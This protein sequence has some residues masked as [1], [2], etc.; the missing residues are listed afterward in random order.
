VTQR[1]ALVRIALAAMAADPTSGLMAD[2]SDWIR[3]LPFPPRTPM[4]ALERAHWKDTLLAWV[5]TAV[6]GAVEIIE[7]QFPQ[8]EE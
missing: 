4:T 1:D 6:P 3:A 7:H 5:R 8:E 2:E